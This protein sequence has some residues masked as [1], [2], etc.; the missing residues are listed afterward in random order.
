MVRRSRKSQNCNLVATTRRVLGLTQEAFGAWLYV[1]GASVRYSALT[2]SSW[3]T[4]R[5]QPGAEVVTICWPVATG[6]VVDTMAEKQ[7]FFSEEDKALLQ[8]LLDQIHPARTDI[9]GENQ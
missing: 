5:R 2:V 9:Q 4:E 1:Q 6:W 8:Y 7:G 3:E